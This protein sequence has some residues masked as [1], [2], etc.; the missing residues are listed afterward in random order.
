MTIDAL[1]S[2]LEKS[3][4]DGLP[5]ENFEMEMRALAGIL[6]NISWIRVLCVRLVVDE[7]TPTPVRR[8]S[9]VRF[10]QITP[11]PR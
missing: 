9:T 5:V 8:R 1:D 11:S 7:Q 10:R 2:V 6:N 4:F 3:S